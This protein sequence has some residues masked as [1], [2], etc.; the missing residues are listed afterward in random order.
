MPKHTP[1]TLLGELS[2]GLRSAGSIFWRL[3]ARFKGV[4]FEGRCFFAGR[5]IISIAPGA[6]IT[7]G[8]GV[9]I[10]SSTRA[11]PLGL[12][13]PSVLRAM[14]PGAR[15]SLARGVGLSGSAICAGVGIEI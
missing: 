4:Q 6:M 12:A 8:D 11:N 13:H 5:P 10:Y 9:S 1:G 3:E 7:I 2:A 15:L 14:A